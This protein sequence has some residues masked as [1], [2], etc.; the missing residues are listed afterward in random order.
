MLVR[1]QAT[2][3][4]QSSAVTS[5]DKSCDKNTAGTEPRSRRVSGNNIETEME[6]NDAAASARPELVNTSV[7]VTQSLF[8]EKHSQEAQVGLSLCA[9]ESQQSQP[10]CGEALLPSTALNA[11]ELEENN[12]ARSKNFADCA[13]S[14]Q[15]DDISE[16]QVPSPDFPVS[17]LL[18]PL[19]SQ[20]SSQRNSERNKCRGILDFNLGSPSVISESGN[21]D[22]LVIA[23]PARRDN[24]TP[25]LS[26]AEKTSDEMEEER[27]EVLR[28][29]TH[30]DVGSSR[31][32]A[33]QS[34]FVVV[35]DS[36]D[37]DS[38]PKGPVVKT[39]RLQSKKLIAEDDVSDENDNVT[40]SFR[41]S[42]CAT[43]N[44]LKPVQSHI[45]INRKGH[46]GI[47]G[48][49]QPVKNDV[50]ALFVKPGHADET[51]SRRGK[52]KLFTGSS[53]PFAESPKEDNSQF[54]LEDDII[55]FA[56]GNPKGTVSS[57]SEL[58]EEKRD[59]VPSMSETSDCKK[60]QSHHGASPSSS[61]ESVINRLT[62]QTPVNS[63]PSHQPPPK[64]ARR[65]SSPLP[66]L[67]ETSSTTSLLASD[68]NINLDEIQVSEW[69]F[70]Q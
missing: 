13:Q 61:G 21:Q 64:V 27:L 51:L 42:K 69:S 53:K 30:G 36:T 39:S 1:P 44:N 45:V 28:T 15:V 46:V 31:S 6:T 55:A 17:P 14:T 16:S 63:L 5:S 41:T 58:N 19:N 67:P 35:I 56:A 22:K 29:P 3:E 33:Q 68:S 49:G 38:Q 50:S 4:G 43:N 54:T 23:V 2:L 47:E 24:K 57:I 26:N 62:V 65:E 59:C 18:I 25:G 52:R 60:Q 48:R 12:R 20:L 9:G 8:G 37:E 66:I 34:D 32:E 70:Q 10:P 7:Q 40:G 11:H